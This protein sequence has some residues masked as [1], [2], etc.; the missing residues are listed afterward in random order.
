[1]EQ[2][3]IS[4]NTSYLI[5]LVNN[6]SDNLQY[7][8]KKIH[9]ILHIQLHAALFITIAH[10]LFLVFPFCSI[11]FHTF[12]LTAVQRFNSII[13]MQSNRNVVIL[14]ASSLSSSSL[15]VL[16]VRSKTAILTG[17]GV[18]VI[19][20]VA[21]FNKVNACYFFISMKIKKNKLEIISQSAKRKH[22]KN[23]YLFRQRDICMQHEGYK[24]EM[25]T[26]RYK[27]F[28]YCIIFL[29]NFFFILFL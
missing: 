1:M 13:I 25:H 19:I 22:K 17:D 24:Q 28:Q 20:I 8:K 7:L 11:H 3:G 16:Y 18:V 5:I 2:N 6:T 9:C 14:I 29:A 23:C 21:V 15:N 4:D 27:C 12:Y 26:H 10:A